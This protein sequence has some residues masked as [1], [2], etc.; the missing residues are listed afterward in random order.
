MSISKKER[1]I[2]RLKNY[3]GQKVK[4]K[5]SIIKKAQEYTGLKSS[6]P[7][8]LLR[9]AEKVYNRKLNQYR[10]DMQKQVKE[11]DKMEAK[12]FRFTYKEFIKLESKAF[13]IASY[14]DSGYSM[15]SVVKIY[16]KGYYKPF[17]IYDNTTTYTSSKWSGRE[18]HGSVSFTFTKK[19]LR[20]IEKIEGVWTVKEK[21]LRAKWIGF[22]GHKNNFKV[23]WDYGYL[24]GSS[25][26]KSK[27][28]ALEIQ[29]VKEKAFKGKF[30]DKDF[31]GK[32]DLESI[33][34][35]WPGIK[36]FCRK[37][38]LNPEYGY[39]IGYLKDLNG[40]GTPYFNKLTSN[41]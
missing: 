38:D 32:K 14:M 25:H 1:A 30:T 35:C 10:K 17:V 18:T 37:H 40:E 33:G 6:D 15:G 11:N 24:I 20:E 39:C 22:L 4:L 21:G 7:E 3:V 16:I 5:S 23:F 31:I 12:H 8:V 27:G 26:G 29:R 36:A 13:D 28:Q 2:I 41:S 34:A 9:N 19:E